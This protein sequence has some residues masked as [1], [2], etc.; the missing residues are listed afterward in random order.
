[1]RMLARVSSS[2]AS[3]LLIVAG[4][5][6][7]PAQA[8]T[9]LLPDLR[10]RT[11]S[12]FYI[13]NV[14]GEKRL[15]FETIVWNGGSGRFDVRMVRPNTSTSRMTVRQRV[16]RSDG[17]YYGFDVNGT[18]GFYAGD[19]HDHWHV[20]KLQK[21]AIRTYN[22]DG[23]VTGP[24]IREG[25]KT[26]FCFFD[27]VRVNASLPGAPSSPQYGNTV[28]G[29]RNSTFVNE[30]LAVG[31]G[32]RYSANT[33]YQWIV[34]N[35]LPDGKYRVQV[36]ADPKNWFREKVETNNSASAYLQIT[37]NTVKML[38]V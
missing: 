32:D 30:G 28:C 26:G 16:Y 15:R 38:T 9:D 13:E 24:E 11:P 36:I 22:P 2:L 31:W 23:A 4:F 10:M 5:T 18:H 21:F 33:A 34:I 19:G 27:N 6:A 17:S 8:A 1:M 12:N 14:G 7:A 25:R 3:G 35:N 20:W 29:R 37:G